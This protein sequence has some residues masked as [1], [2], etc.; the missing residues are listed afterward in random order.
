MR[1]DAF[2]S[3]PPS[4]TFL[5]GYEV[6]PPRGHSD[7][8]HKPPVVERGFFFDICSLL[9]SCFPPFRAQ[10]LIAP[11]PIGWRKVKRLPTCIYMLQTEQID[12]MLQL[13]TLS[14]HTPWKSFS[15][16]GSVQE[17]TT[18]F[19]L[20][21]SGK[22]RRKLLSCVFQT[23]GTDSNYLCPNITNDKKHFCY[24]YLL[25][26][27]T[28]FFFYLSLSWTLKNLL[29]HDSCSVVV[30]KSFSAAVERKNSS[31][32]SCKMFIPS[33]RSHYCFVITEQ[34]SWWR[35]YYSRKHP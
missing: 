28:L 29:F 23:W 5:P 22:H 12:N 7:I 18:R 15:T 20:S 4:F 10:F 17:A 3:S 35:S 25:N 32:F 16:A 13:Y 33:C 26:D 24:S 2:T 6:L 27:W 11:P 8:R 19:C 30:W 9:R 1:S 14:P 34:T 21:I 31:L